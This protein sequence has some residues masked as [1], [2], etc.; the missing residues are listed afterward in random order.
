MA[1]CRLVPSCA[2][3]LLALGVAPAAAAGGTPHA[4]FENG[5][6]G[7]WFGMQG[8]DGVGGGT[9]HEP[10]GGNPS[11]C[12]HTVFNNFGIGFYNVSDPSWACDWT[13]ATQVTVSI[14]IRVSSISF[15]GQNVSRPWV[16]ELRDRDGATGGYPW[17]SVWIRLATISAATHGQWT[18]LSVTFDP[19][20]TVLPPGWRGSGAEDPVTY[21]PVLPAGVTFADVLAGVDTVA[22]TT[23]QPGMFFGFTDHDIRIDNVRVERTVPS[24]A[25][26]NGDGAV[27][28]D[29][30]GMLLGAWG[31]AAGSP[32][33]LNQ[34]GM[35]DGIDLGMMLAAWTTP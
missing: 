32:A 35:V 27:N 8:D 22:F 3:V 12:L 23:L 30:L 17:N 20:S 29:D 24:P 11:G 7:G 10:T 9:W 18:T 4:D 34:D 33:D 28:G 1:A 16:L 26:L 14:D 2:S 5:V 13:E 25:D 19:R 6:D 31:P 15:F 21:E